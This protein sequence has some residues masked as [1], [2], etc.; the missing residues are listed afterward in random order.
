MADATIIMAGGSGTR[1]WPASIGNR[2]KQL[3]RIGG[4]ESLIAQAVIRAA[5]ATPSGPIVIV[6]HREHV[7]GIA[8]D[9][10]ELSAGALPGIASRVV[11]LPEPV[12]RNTAPAIAL[13]VAFLHA[14]CGADASVLV[15]TADHVIEPLSAFVRDA[16]VACEVARDGY[17]VCF[18]IPPERPET[19]YGYIHAGDPVGT[20]SGAR[21]RA[22]KEKPD[23]PTASRYVADGG[24]YWNSGMFCFTAGLFGSE[25]SVHAP[26]ISGRF[27]DAGPIVVSE[28]PDGA[29]YADPDALILLYE[30]LPKISVDYALL[31]R[32]DR[33]AVVPATFGWND[34]GSWDEVARLSPGGAPEGAPVVQ[35]DAE[36][37]HIDTDLP[38]AVCGV[39]DIHVI[40]KN[41]RIL[42]CRRGSSQ[43]VKDAVEAM[44]EGA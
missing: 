13:G 38:V 9:V 7:A 25:L 22:F 30:S 41:N 11:Y 28:H 32:S 18:G 21:V 24:Y 39:S 40:V 44:G 27:A 19:G 12:G 31:E 8:C 36:G 35:I 26:E 33:V 20:G 37:N 43:L 1:L 14:Q 23:A 29:R 42:I 34:V 6:T 10:D 16:D 15:L 3:L 5:A 17:L 2:P 4:R